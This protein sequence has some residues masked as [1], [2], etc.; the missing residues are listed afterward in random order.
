[1]NGLIFLAATLAA[2]STQW[3]TAPTV[4]LEAEVQV[5]LETE[6]DA[7]TKRRAPGIEIVEIPEQ[8]PLVAERQPDGSIVLR[9]RRLDPP[10]NSDEEVEQ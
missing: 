10:E 3:D 4:K 9:H 5:V 8:P 2:G 7:S 6:A 1:M